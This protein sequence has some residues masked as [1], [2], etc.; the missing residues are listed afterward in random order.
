MK[1]AGI[2][3]KVL[4]RFA[5]KV[6]DKGKF[7]LRDITG[8]RDH[9]GRSALNRI[10]RARLFVKIGP[11]AYQRTSAD[12]IKEYYAQRQK[13]WAKRGAPG[14][15][16]RKNFW[17]E[18]KAMGPTSDVSIT[19][20]DEDGQVMVR[21]GGRKILGYDVAVVPLKKGNGVNED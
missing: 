21:I 20:W 18:K 17:T 7:A 1:Y 9:A 13:G 19:P 5:K 12:P 14:V 8:A 3:N 6:P 15:K 11:G 4:K 2:T 10:M 16:K